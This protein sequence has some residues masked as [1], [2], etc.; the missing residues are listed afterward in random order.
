MR[1]S[2]NNSQ[3]ESEMEALEAR[4][5]IEELEKQLLMKHLELKDAQLGIRGLESQLAE[6]VCCDGWRRLRRLPTMGDPIQTLIIGDSGIGKVRIC[7]E[8]LV[9]TP[10]RRHAFCTRSA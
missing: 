9:L 5:K 6:R 8:G 4:Q 3:G 2:H 7:C 1:E 10:L